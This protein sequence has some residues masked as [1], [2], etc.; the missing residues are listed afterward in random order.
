[1]A[2]HCTLHQFFGVTLLVLRVASV[3]MASHGIYYSAL[4]PSHESWMRMY[5]RTYPNET[6]K[7]KR[8]KIYAE[9]VKL[10][11]SFN[12]NRHKN[13]KF[14]LKANKFADLTHEEFTKTYTNR[15]LSYYR[16][17]GRLYRPSLPGNRSTPQPYSINWRD[18]GAVTDVKS[19]GNCGSCWA[20]AAVA[21]IEGIIQIKTG[22]LVSMSEQEL[23]DCVPPQKECRSSCDC[24]YVTKAFDFVIDNGSLTTEHNYPYKGVPGACNFS[25]NSATFQ[26]QAGGVTISKYEWAEDEKELL[27]AVARQPVTVSVSIL[28]HKKFFHLYGAGVATDIGCGDDDEVNHSMTVVGYG[29]DQN[30]TD[31]WLLKNSYGSGWG[32]NGYIKM[33]RGVDGGICGIIKEA[34]YPVIT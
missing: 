12:Q 31:Y 33:A 9:N 28:D 1:M 24:G 15:G 6:V 2:F 23:V 13:H 19:Q 20:F 25:L 8:H 4:S 7:E 18:K 3:A 14:T 27:E 30:D 10:I 16:R 29:T 26:T 11:D 21:A 5:H 32:D 22:K 34:V 17:G